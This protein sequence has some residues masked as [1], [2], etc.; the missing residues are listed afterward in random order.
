M[1]PRKHPEGLADRD[2]GRPDETLHKQH[3][4]SHTVPP[5][6]AARSCKTW[7]CVRC[8]R[9]KG[10]RAHRDRGADLSLSQIMDI[11]KLLTSTYPRYIDAESRESVESVG[12]AMV[13]RDELRGTPEGEQDESKFGVMEQILG[14]MSSEVGRI[15]KRSR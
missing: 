8:L 2:A 5:R 7:R 4:G 12:V 14:W 10:V 9:A 3:K 11:F 13:R 6:R 15:Q 1:A